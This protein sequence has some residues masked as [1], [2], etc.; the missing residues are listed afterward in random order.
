MVGRCIIANRF[1]V[2]E[3]GT[4]D[5]SDTTHWATS[6]GAG[7][8]G[9]SVPGAGD[10]AIFD[11]LSAPL[12]GTCTVNT[13]VTVQQ[14]TMGLFTGTLDF[15]TN[16]NNVTLSVAFSN[17]GTGTRTLN[18]GDGTWTL[19]A[20]SGTVWNQST[21]TG[22]TFN[23]NASTLVIAASSTPSAERAIVLGAS[24]TYN[25]V[26]ISDPS[27][28]STTERVAVNFT[29]ASNTITT[30][31][32]TN[33][34]WL[35]LPTITITNGFNYSGSLGNAILIHSSD[36]NNQL[37]LSVGGAVTLGWA[38]IQNVIKSGAGSI[39]ATNSFDLGGNTGVTIALPPSSR[40]IS[41]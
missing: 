27:I 25:A 32:I 23:S 13:T 26:T 3:G 39:T 29:S 40:I 17:S 5:A 30:F 35:K 19:T 36:A 15:A 8:G 6:S 37:T 41:G 21:I 24:L 2:L 22:L 34:Y 12:G 16:D 33:A 1:W 14:I 4:W 7:V 18:M 20:A 28:S 38:A 11:A 31:S 9:A 10:V